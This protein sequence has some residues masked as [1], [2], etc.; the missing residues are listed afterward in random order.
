[1]IPKLGGC[2]CAA[3]KGREELRFLVFLFLPKKGQTNEKNRSAQVWDL[4][5][6]GGVYFSSRPFFEN[7]LQ[8]G[9]GLAGK[10]GHWLG[11]S[12]I[13]FL[14]SDRAMEKPDSAYEN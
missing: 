10:V 2:R 8:I 9:A 1:M 13:S 3:P 7:L 4:H 5:M 14:L 12:Q 11:A 6:F